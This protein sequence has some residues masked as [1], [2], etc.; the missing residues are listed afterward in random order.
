MTS[1]V[2]G[3]SG[4]TFPDGTIQTTAVATPNY[5]IVVSNGTTWSDSLIG[6]TVGDQITW[7]GTNW[8]VQQPTA[9]GDNSLLWY[10][11]S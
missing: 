10:F 2:S 4:Y 8:V 1:I 6:F 9:S 11:M 5:G 3:T 7:N